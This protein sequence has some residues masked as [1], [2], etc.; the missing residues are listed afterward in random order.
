MEKVEIEILFDFIEIKK[1][2]IFEDN[3][4]I[5]RKKKIFFGKRYDFDHK[6]H[7]DH[8]NM[9]TILLKSQS[10][11]NFNGNFYFPINQDIPVSLL[12]ILTLLAKF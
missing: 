9:I 7:D 1:M 12:K 4:K 10:N 5:Q 8:I 2:K 11:F 6:M 3:L